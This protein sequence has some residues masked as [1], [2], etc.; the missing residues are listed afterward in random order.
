MAAEVSLERTYTI[1]EFMQLPDDG[2]AYDL[3]D[4]RLERMSPTGGEH[5]LIAS[6]LNV[7]LASYVWE[8]GLGDT[9]AAETAFVLDATTNNV[10]GADVAFVAVA[11]LAVVGVGAVP[12]PPDLAIEV[13]S[14]SDRLTGARKKVAAYQR[15]GVPLV[16]V[17]NPR[18]HTVEVY[19]PA[20]AHP[21]TLGL[22]DELDGE[23]VVPGFT[24][25]VHKVFGNR[26][27]PKT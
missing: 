10:R 7:Y 12:F 8:H 24:L 23:E 22:D 6:R 14:P 11:R 3:V 15:A 2:Y 5:G 4:G 9:F 1:E 26:Q 21:T 18:R 16:W 20:D 13:I 25:P 19:H 17:V 27:G